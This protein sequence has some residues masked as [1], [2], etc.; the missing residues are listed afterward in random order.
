MGFIG[1]KLEADDAEAVVNA[2]QGNKSARVM[3]RA[4][5]GPMLPQSYPIMV[6][7]QNPGSWSPCEGMASIARPPRSVP[8]MTCNLNKIP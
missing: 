5:V 2:G 8:M 7:R 4:D 3:V 6:K 1:L